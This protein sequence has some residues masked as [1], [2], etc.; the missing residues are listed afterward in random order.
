MLAD[1]HQRIAC[2]RAAHEC[3]TQACRPPR[4]FR[5]PACRRTARN[6]ARPAATGAS[7]D[8]F[9]C[10]RDPSSPEHLPRRADPPHRRH[11]RR[12]TADRCICRTRWD[13]RA[14]I[15]R[16][17]RCCCNRS[18]A[19]V[20]SRCR[21]QS[22]CGW[23]MPSAKPKGSIPSRS[24]VSSQRCSSNASFHALPWLPCTKACEPARLGEEHHHQMRHARRRSPIPIATEH[25]FPRHPGAAN[26]S[27]PSFP[28]GTPREKPARTERGTPSASRPAAVNATCIAVGGGGSSSRRRW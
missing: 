1:R 25:C 24:A 4:N 19:D 12:S 9:R 3:R 8:T 13:T 27:L 18:A 15:P 16:A 10:G 21:A 7:R 23:L 11:R 28:P 6:S 20:T 26:D 14:G 17:R 22:I 2:S 5:P